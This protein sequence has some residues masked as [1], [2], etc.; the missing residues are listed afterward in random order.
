MSIPVRHA[1][2]ADAPEI[3][4]CLAVLGYDT[5][6]ALVA[7]RLTAFAASDVDVVL[8]AGGAPG[9]ALH[10]VVSAHALPLFHTT[11]RL[12]RLT[13]L[14]VRGE[15]QGRGVGRALV[16]AAEAWAWRVGARRVEVTSGDHR[17]GAHAFYQALGYALDERR[18]IKHATAR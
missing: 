5:P 10:G 3:A 7:E 6:P 17:P 9:A 12:V 4:A 1:E 13:A 2:I 8:V 15:A 11:G 18:F 16:Q 14:A